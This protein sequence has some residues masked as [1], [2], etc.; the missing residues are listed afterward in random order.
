MKGYA[1]DFTSSEHAGFRVH[2][3][4]V[5]KYVADLANGGVRDDRWYGSGL[6]RKRG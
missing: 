1:V 2:A 6:P 4:Y 5:A 3:E